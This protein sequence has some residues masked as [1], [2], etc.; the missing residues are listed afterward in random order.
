M[1]FG[2]YLIFE[3]IPLFIDSRTDMYGDDFLQAFVDATL[4]KD[5]TLPDLLQ[6]YDIQWT[7]FPADGHTVGVLDHMAGWKRIYADNTAVVHIR[8]AAVNRP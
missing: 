5:E 7:L 4:I 6:R 3:G 8:T 1:Q 2:G